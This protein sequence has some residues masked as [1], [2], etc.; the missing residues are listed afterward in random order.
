M[1]FHKDV[2]SLH[3]NYVLDSPMRFRNKRCEYSLESDN[4]QIPKFSD[5]SHF[6]TDDFSLL[7]SPIGNNELEMWEDPLIH[8]Y[9]CR[10]D[11]CTTTCKQI[12]RC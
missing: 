5:L 6:K 4:I 3:S 8:A 1:S 7:P 9:L 11:H 2:D 12:R 10:T